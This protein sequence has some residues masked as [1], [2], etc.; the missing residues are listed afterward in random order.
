VPTI[1][2]PGD[3]V[4]A[5]RR[6][7]HRYGKER[8]QSGDLWL[9]DRVGAGGVPVVVLIHGG[10]WRSVYTRR[11]MNPL[12][13]SIALR[14]WAAWNIEYRRTGRI[15]GGGGWPSTFTDVGRAIDHVGRLAGTDPSRVVTCGH[16]AGGHLAL[17]AAA[18]DG[19]M[20]AVDAPAPAVQLCG[21]V[22]LA[23][24]SDL[25]GAATL[26][27]G[28]GAVTRF[29]G[30]TPQSHPE[31]YELASPM[32]LLP[33]GIP[34][35]LVHGLSDDVVPA[36]MSEEYQLRAREAGDAAVFA[37]IEAMGHR[38]L[39]DPGRGAWPVI[40]DQLDRLLSV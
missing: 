14:G 15:G 21:A 27:L 19:L 29:L 6:S 40:A 39:I 16:S 32:A 13:R 37:P 4:T 33:L 12:A 5:V 1:L 36:S 34:Q 25:V 2:T 35:V 30:G 3:T 22:S 7:R 8:W 28:G 10:F 31:R 24:V 26:G 17:W 18:R 23:G 20:A 38:E 11:L 9:P